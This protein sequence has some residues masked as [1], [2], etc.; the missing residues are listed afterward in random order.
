[1]EIILL[2]KITNLGGKTF[3]MTKS[4]DYIF[5]SSK[6]L[7]RKNFV[8]LGIDNDNELEKT[9]RRIKEW[10]EQITKEILTPM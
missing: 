3:G 7:R 1:M 2:E 5:K 4:D 9:D 8:G 10:C 6:A